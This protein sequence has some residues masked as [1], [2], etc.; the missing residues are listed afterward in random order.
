MKKLFFI[1]SL[2]LIVFSACQKEV[3]CKNNFEDEDIPSSSEAR[4]ATNI[5]VVVPLPND[6][7]GTPDITDPNNDPDLTK[8]KTKN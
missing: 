7:T 1:S 2:L 8:R 6:T 3:I 5:F 4:V